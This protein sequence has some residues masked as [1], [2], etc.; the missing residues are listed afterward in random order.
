MTTSKWIP[1]AVHNL[2]QWQK[3]RARSGSKLCQCGHRI[4]STRQYCEAC[5]EQ[6]AA[7][8][9]QQFEADLDRWTAEAER[10][11]AGES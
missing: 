2:R 5:A 3:D 6:K 9:V 8:F 11:D 1:L 10:L 7:D 4:S